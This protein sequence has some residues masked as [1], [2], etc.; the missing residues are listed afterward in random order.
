MGQDWILI[1]LMSGTSLDGLDA[2]AIR[3]GPHTGPVGEL[4][5]ACTSPWPGDL[6]DRVRQLL[7]H[8]EAS[9]ANLAALNVEL[10]AALA[11][12]A[13]A[14]RLQAGLAW[15]DIDLIGS[16]GQT[17]W[18]QPHGPWPATWQMGEPAEIAARTGV[19]VVADFRPIDVAL[20]GQ[21][22]PL[23]PLFDQV[24]FAGPEPI[25]ALNIGG[26]PNL[27]YVPGGGDPSGVI[28]F[29]TG[30]GNMV[31][32]RLAWHATAGRQVCD[33]DGRLAASGTVRLDWLEAWL[34]DGYFTAAPPKSTGRERF[35][36]AYAD[37][38][39]DTYQEWP[40][41]LIATAVALTAESIA[42]AFRTFLPQ[43]PA[44]CA[45]SGGGWHHPGMMAALA[46]RLPCRLAGTAEWGIDPDAKEAHAF[47]WFAWGAWH[48]RV[49]PLSH[50]T[51]A[52]QGLPLGK[53]VP[54]ANFGRIVS[55]RSACEEQ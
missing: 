45:V 9:L 39:W 37:R 6:A 8:P 29:D 52:R 26:I 35:G 31:I 53:I 46:D 44:A 30:P 21:G 23:V 48:G 38:L 2:A 50:V 13:D 3:M 47:A 22:A 36:T 24:A 18:H 49:N 54:G 11:G 55:R 20:G 33:L 41:D 10:G 43:L 16:H 7:A 1:G 28:A 17:I 4:I 19:T 51:G 14:V 25:V 42:R 5:T 32:D 40:N 34:A 12:A 15:S 27:T